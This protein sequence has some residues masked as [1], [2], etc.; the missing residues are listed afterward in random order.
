MLVE[1][2]TVLAIALCQAEAEKAAPPPAQQPIPL[3]TAAAGAQCDANTKR[4][5]V[6]PDA[7]LSADGEPLS[8]LERA[9]PCALPGW[10]EKELVAQGYELAGARARARARDLRHLRRHVQAAVVGE[11]DGRRGR[12][13]RLPPRRKRPPHPGPL[14]RFAGARGPAR[15]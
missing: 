14:P 6:A 11:L 3:A 8:G 1:A 15:W 9:P 13:S 2:L 5:L 12:P 4:C 10:R 7:E